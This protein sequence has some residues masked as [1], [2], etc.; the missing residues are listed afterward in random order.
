MTMSCPLSARLAAAATM[1]LCTFDAARAQ[2][3]SAYNPEADFRSVESEHFRLVFQEGVDSV[4]RRMLGVLE[5][6]YAGN[7][8][9]LHPRP[10]HERLVVVLETRNRTANGYVA[11]LSFHSVWYGG[12]VGLSGLPWFETLALHEGRHQIQDLHLRS[13]GVKRALYLALGDQ[14]TAI[15]SGLFVPQW[16]MEGDAVG[17]ETV[18][19]PGGRGRRAAFTMPLRALELEGRRMGYYQNYL[20]RDDDRR[21]H[22]DHYQLGYLMTTQARRLYGPDVWARTLDRTIS[23]LVFPT[24]DGALR[25]VTGSVGYQG[26]YASTFDTLGALWRRQGASME[27]T[28]TELAVA[29]PKPLWEAR[30][31]PEVHEGRVWFVDQDK[32][33]GLWIARGADD[34]SIERIHPLPGELL[35]ATSFMERSVA[36]HRGRWAWTGSVPSP[37][38][39]SVVSHDVYLYDAATDRERRLTRGAGYLAVGFSGDG[40]TL[41]AH[42]L[43]TVHVERLALIDVETGS[44]LANKAVPGY[45]HGIEGTPDG[46][47]V[48]ARIDGDGYSIVEI[49]PKDMS[50][51]NL[52]GPTR[53][54]ALRSPSI[55][56]GLLYY[57]SDL[58]GLDDIWA[59]DLSTGRRFLVV[60]ARYGAFFPRVR[61]D[62]LYYSDYTT[63]GHDVRRTALRPE[64]FTPEDSVP[65]VRED[66]FAPL[67]AQEPH[68][69]ATAAAISVRGTADSGPAPR[70]YSPLGH[71]ID[72][73]SRSFSVDEDHVEG[74]LVQGDKLGILVGRIG[75]GYDWYHRGAIAEGSLEYSQLL[76]V[77]GVY[78]GYR[79]VDVHDSIPDRDVASR[80]ADLGV[81]IGLPIDLDEG[82]WTRR[83]GVSAAAG[84]SDV[85][86]AGPIVDPEAPADGRAWPVRYALRGAFL[87]EKPALAVGPRLGLVLEGG[88]DH[89]VAGASDWNSQMPWGRARVFLPGLWWTHSIELAGAGEVQLDDHGYSFQD[90]S[91]RVDRAATGYYRDYYMGSAKYALPLFH[92]AVPLWKLLY[93]RGMDA[94]AY[95]EYGFGH[96][97]HGSSEHGNVGGALSLRANLFSNLALRI[98]P[99]LRVGYDLVDEETYAAWQASV[100][101]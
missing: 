73:H 49:D 77:L 88:F 71:A 94:G 37:R 81:S 89:T 36:F 57:Q 97:R 5:A 84:V 48:A 90:V 58:R 86:N 67:L 29:A 70:P 54:E 35:E 30:W 50:T 74:T 87:E 3:E 63:L 69:A 13:K 32:R 41:L 45:F 2:A 82:R 92:C 85:D 25:E 27:P 44:V 47:F 96:T 72:L 65:I 83:L 51:R 98:S 91:G 6:T 43:D 64:A 11:P 100:I 62:S 26:L 7:T 18:L 40:R 66:F 23:G 39:P 76:P 24:M 20:G 61:G 55:A 56:G 52:I 8:A 42:E 28:P 75:A 79:H 99:T 12:Q 33:R 22:A 78:G 9:T 38:W 10:D 60:A 95:G 59:K 14:S 46:K 1:V 17:M 68:A 93:V 19:S 34:G 101:F 21:L 16:Y 15:V 80:R 53:D 4:A 31:M